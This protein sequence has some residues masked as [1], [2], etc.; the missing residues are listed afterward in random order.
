MPSQRDLTYYGNSCYEFLVAALKEERKLKFPN[1]AAA[2][3][4]RRTLY[5]YRYALRDA[6]FSGD[7]VAE[8]KLK[9][10][11]L[12]E[13]CVRG[14]TLVAHKR[15]PTIVQEAQSAIRASLSHSPIEQ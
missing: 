9:E 4:Y 11:K 12:V 10:V 3:T 5:N 7:K 6:A 15:P 1:E 13:L 14:D 2:S 8:E